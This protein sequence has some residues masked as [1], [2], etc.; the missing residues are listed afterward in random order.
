MRSEKYRIG[1]ELISSIKCDRSEEYRRDRGQQSFDRHGLQV[2]NKM[3][4][5]ALNIVILQTMYVS[6]GMCDSS[7]KK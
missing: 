6:Q 7:V 2:R 3:V 5:E 4:S 1:R